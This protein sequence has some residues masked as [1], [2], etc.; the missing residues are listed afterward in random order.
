MLDRVVE[1]K[2]FRVRV[3]VNLVTGMIGYIVFLVLVCL[4]ILGV[5]LFSSGISSGDLISILLP[6]YFVI[7]LVLL[8]A[9]FSPSIFLSYFVFLLPYYPF[10]KYLVF[11]NFIVP[12]IS[13]VLFGLGGIGFVIG[14]VF[15]IGCL[16]MIL[17]YPVLFA[18]F[19][20]SACNGGLAERFNSQF[21]KE[22]KRVALKKG[23]NQ[24]SFKSSDNNLGGVQVVSTSLTQNDGNDSSSLVISTI[25]QYS[26]QSHNITEGKTVFVKDQ[27][28][29]YAA[30]NTVVVYSGEMMKNNDGMFVRHGKGMQR[31]VEG[32]NSGDTFEGSF[33]GGVRTG[34][35]KYVHSNG[36]IYEGEYSNDCRN[37]KG[38]MIFPNGDVFEGSYKNGFREGEG[39]STFSNG[40]RIVCNWSEDRREGSGVSYYPNGDKEEGVWNEHQKNGRFLFFSHDGQILERQWKGGI[41][42]QES[43]VV[44]QRVS[45]GWK[46]DIQCIEDF[47]IQ[48]RQPI[49][50]ISNFVSEN[51]DFNSPLEIVQIVRVRSITI[52]DQNQVFVSGNNCMDRSCPFEQSQHENIEIIRVAGV[53]NENDK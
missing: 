42:A 1:E 38:K 52:D 32:E 33:V 14:F 9:L 43:S 10:A 2:G 45:E 21:E 16:V 4:I 40:E 36:L 8:L 35:G 25:S 24:D 49:I 6:I 28:I 48:E 53:V 19:I 39:I 44:V 51:T 15:S 5:L 34:Y 50:D 46:Q 23:L 22:C 26:V 41:L 7:F 13:L 20:I 27:H 47:H 31:Y 29:K 17:F 18:F 3:V 30:G 12:L 37:G 11:L